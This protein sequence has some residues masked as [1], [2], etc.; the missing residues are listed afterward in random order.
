MP[1][2]VHASVEH[3]QAMQLEPVIDDVLRNAGTKELPPGDYALL[4]VRDSRNE[5]IYAA[6]LGFTGDIPVNSR[7]V[8]HLRH[9]GGQ[10][11][12]RGAQSW[13]KVSAASARKAAPA[14]GTARRPPGAVFS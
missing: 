1:H 6:Q 14:I 12:A 11:R 2:G 4:A 10:R 5:P 9:F 7:S 8:G 13:A 3:V